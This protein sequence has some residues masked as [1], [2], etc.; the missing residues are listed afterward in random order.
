MEKQPAI[1]IS[2]LVKSYGDQKALNGINFT[3]NKGEILGFLG[4]NGAGK[5]TT[6]NILTGYLAADAGT[7]KINGISIFD[8]PRETKKMIGYLPEIPPLY[9]DMT[10]L[11]Y[12][13]FVFDLKMVKANRDTHLTQVMKCVKIL[14]VQK[15]LIKNL[16]KGYRQ[17][18][19]FAQALVG[20]PEILILDEPTVGLDPNQIMEIRALIR[21]LGKAH[22]IILSTHI[23][24]EVSAVCDR[25]IIINH[26]TLA[27]EG[28]L[29]DLDAG[30][31]QAGISLRVKG[32]QE[33]ITQALAAGNLDN[34]IQFLGSFEDGTEDFIICQKEDDIREK[35]FTLFSDRRLPILSMSA[36]T[37]SLEE[38]FIKATGQPEVNNQ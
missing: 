7:V 4:P 35:L 32:T 20:N 22:T 8:E 24:G 25:Y 23:L 3:V 26:G 10:V 1:E 15:R 28:N 31:G 14:D 36:K 19:G 18:V 6:M 16:S 34:S 5:S 29:H 2:G 30:A 11:E 13:R 17:R 12:L 21:A 38:L 33:E 37:S 9:T 27:A